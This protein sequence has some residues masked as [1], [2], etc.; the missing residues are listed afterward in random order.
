MAK[1]KN[2]HDAFEDGDGDKPKTIKDHKRGSAAN[3]HEV[4]IDGKP[5]IGDNSFEPSGQTLDELRELVAE[6]DDIC[7]KIDNDIATKTAP[8]R[9]K[10][11][12]AKALITAAKKRLVE[13]GYKPA[14]LD[15]IIGQLR[16]ARKS[17]KRAEQLDPDHL[18]QLKAYNEAWKDFRDT[19]LGRA[20]EEREAAPALN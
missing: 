2:A 9:E 14:V 18:K 3:D 15:V 12:A 16:D 10:K 11:A 4:P 6:Q 17:K 5:G 1:G 7:E 8:L 13:D 19:D 20:A